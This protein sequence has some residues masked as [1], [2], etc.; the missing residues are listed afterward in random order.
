MNLHVDCT[1]LAI[2]RHNNIVATAKGAQ[3][4]PVLCQL[5]LNNSSLF[6][7]QPLQRSL[8]GDLFRTLH[9][10]YLIDLD[11]MP[12]K[13]TMLLFD[14]LRRNSVGVVP[15]AFG[16]L[17]AVKLIGK[18]SGAGHNEQQKCYN[19]SRVAQR[20]QAFDFAIGYHD[21]ILSIGAI[22]FATHNH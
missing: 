21:S 5:S 13:L 17:P 16:I 20:I 10:P 11:A 1:E 14:L 8:F 3:Q 18:Q 2:T 15:V 12:I 9:S 7:P 19:K 22:K 4:N 6:G